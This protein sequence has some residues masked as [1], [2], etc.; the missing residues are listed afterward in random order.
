MLQQLAL[1]VVQALPVLAVEIMEDRLEAKAQVL[2]L[3]Q[4]KQEKGVVPLE[5]VQVLVQAQHH[6]KVALENRILQGS[7]LV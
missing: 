4:D 2:G 7:A 3:G 6:L 5:L 1:E